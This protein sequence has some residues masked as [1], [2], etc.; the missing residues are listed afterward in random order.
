[1]LQI[2]PEET[3]KEVDIHSLESYARN[4]EG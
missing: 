3:D 1:L 4:Y 2:C